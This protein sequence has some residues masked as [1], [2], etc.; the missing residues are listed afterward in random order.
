MELDLVLNGREVRHHQAEHLGARPICRRIA[1]GD[2]PAIL[3][4]PQFLHH[5]PEQQI[6]VVPL[7]EE[8]DLVS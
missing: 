1:G 4:D 5:Q 2:L 6:D 7:P 8:E 3:P